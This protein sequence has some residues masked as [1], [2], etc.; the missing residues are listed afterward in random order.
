VGGLTLTGAGATNYT[1]TQPAGLT[2]NIT[3]AGESRGT[4]T[5]G[6]TAN[7][8]TYDG[9]TVATISSNNVVLNGVQAGM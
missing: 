4:I 5:S 2:A 3:A 9:T 6:I 1:L 7:N 8:K